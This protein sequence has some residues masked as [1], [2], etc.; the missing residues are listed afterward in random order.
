MTADLPK[1]MAGSKWDGLI[2]KQQH[3]PSEG[4]W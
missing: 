4:E 1:M 2:T 3:I